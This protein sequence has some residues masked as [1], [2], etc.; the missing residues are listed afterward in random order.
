MWSAT[1]M[2]HLVLVRIS[3]VLK[4]DPKQFGE[5]EIYLWQTSQSQCIVKGSQEE[6]Q[7]RNL[8]ARAA[9]ESKEEN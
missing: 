9:A 8:E 6:T 1:M 7:G 5:E 3:I 2:N 4:K